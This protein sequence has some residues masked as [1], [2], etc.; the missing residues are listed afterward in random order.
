MHVTSCVLTIKT[1][2]STRVGSSEEPSVTIRK[3]FASRGRR[4]STRLTR[5]FACRSV[6]NQ[7][8]HLFLSPTHPHSRLRLPYRPRGSS[9]VGGIRGAAQRSYR[10]THVA[11]SRSYLSVNGSNA[12]YQVGCKSVNRVARSAYTTGSVVAVHLSTIFR[13]SDEVLT[14]HFTGRLTSKQP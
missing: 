12:E 6:R 7:S 13:S 1:V 11:T 5:T 14:P 4:R 8:G 3:L 9:D 2:V 10:A